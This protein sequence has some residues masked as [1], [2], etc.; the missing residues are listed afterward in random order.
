MFTLSTGGRTDKEAFFRAV[1]EALP[2]DPPLGPG[3]VWDALA[4]SVW[5]GLQE[6]G[7]PLVVVVW[8]DAG[9]VAGAVGDHGIAL[10]ILRE[11]VTSLADDWFTVG[12]PNGV[13]VYVAEAA[14]GGADG[15]TEA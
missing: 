5:N 8:P 7:A 12:R 3:R 10:D 14:P 11:L 4:D 9:P 15:P 1:R 13:A 6:L 2:L